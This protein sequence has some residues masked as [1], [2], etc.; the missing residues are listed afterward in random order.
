MHHFVVAPDN[1]PEVRCVARHPK[2]PAA[3]GG[4]VLQAG[5]A[6]THRDRHGSEWSGPAAS[7]P[8]PTPVPTPASGA[9]ASAVELERG[10]KI[11]PQCAEEVKAAALLCRFCEYRFDTPVAAP[12][13]FP[14]R[15]PVEPRGEVVSGATRAADRMNPA[16]VAAGVAGGV[17]LVVSVFLPLIDNTT[18]FGRIV[19]NTLIQHGGWPLIVLGVGAALAAILG[20][21]RARR[22]FLIIGVI[23]VAYVIYLATDKSLRTVYPIINGEPTG[24]GTLADVGIGV[25]VAAVGAALVLIAGFFPTTPM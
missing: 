8:P 9:V 7:T 23:A 24:T 16:A 11:C 15:G 4:C 12:A 5:H 20:G 17:V 10:T 18:D 3:A 22:S 14:G 25:Y 1:P 21:K 13:A 19:Q 2:Y 6:G